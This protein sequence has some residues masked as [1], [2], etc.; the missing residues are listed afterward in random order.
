MSDLIED[1]SEEG[2]TIFNKYVK[3]AETL[4]SKKDPDGKVAMKMLNKLEGEFGLDLGILQY[5]GLVHLSTI[6][7]CVEDLRKKVKELEGKL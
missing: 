7:A 6:Q 4:S 1:F 3:V 2:N 5:V